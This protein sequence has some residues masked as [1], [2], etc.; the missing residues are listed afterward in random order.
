MKILTSILLILTISVRSF[1]PL[2]DYVINYDYITIQFCENR[3]K[4]ELLCNGICYI[5]KELAKTEQNTDN[6]H[7]KLDVL[8]EFIPDKSFEF[9]VKENLEFFENY[10][11]SNH[12]LFALQ[13]FY[14]KIFHPPLP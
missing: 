11:V 13:E 9:R 1:L 12:C 2:I 3:N 7:L 5:K 14:A 6:Q 10:I 4:P 8:E